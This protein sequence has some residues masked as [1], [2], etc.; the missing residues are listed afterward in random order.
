[1]FSGISPLAKVLIGES[2]IGEIRQS[3]SE[4][5]VDYRIFCLSINGKRRK[6]SFRFLLKKI[7]FIFL[8][9]KKLVLRR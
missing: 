3:Q 7:I 9:N 5:I 4:F 6:K 1:M 2:L 8:L